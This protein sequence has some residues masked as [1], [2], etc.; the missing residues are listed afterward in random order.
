VNGANRAKDFIFLLL[1]WENDMDTPSLDKQLIASK[2]ASA[3]YRLGIS[4]DRT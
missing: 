2:T 4:G 1:H 3:R